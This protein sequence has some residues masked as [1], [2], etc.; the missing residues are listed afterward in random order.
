MKIAN[1]LSK[2]T[3]EDVWADVLIRDINEMIF[4]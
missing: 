2:I 1:I 4:Q 3:L